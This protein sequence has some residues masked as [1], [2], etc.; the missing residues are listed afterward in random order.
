MDLLLKVSNSKIIRIM[1]TL[2]IKTLIKSDIKNWFDLVGNI[3]FHKTLMEHSNERA[4]A[5]KTF[6]LVELGK[7]IAWEATHFGSK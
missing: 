4:I 1:P 7:W 5:G 2:E 6:G 3:D